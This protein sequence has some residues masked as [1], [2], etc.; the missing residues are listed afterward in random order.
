[1]EGYISDIGSTVSISDP[2]PNPRVFQSS[3]KETVEDAP[4]PSDEASESSDPPISPQTE[5]GQPTTSPS[6]PSPAAAN[7]EAKSAA[8]YNYGPIVSIVTSSC[9]LIH[10]GF[11]Q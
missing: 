3:Q 7:D 1:M 6:S 8:I 2:P 4:S 5:T 10:L 11:C 9:L